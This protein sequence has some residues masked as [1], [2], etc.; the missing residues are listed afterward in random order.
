VNDFS[1]EICNS[2]SIAELA[3][4]TFMNLTG[5]L[6]ELLLQSKNEQTFSGLL[7]PQLQGMM[8]TQESRTLLELK[9]VD[10]QKLHQPTNTF[11]SS[12]N[13]HDIAIVN[14][15]GQF[16]II[17]ENKAWYHFDGAKGKLEKKVEKGVFEQI[18]SDTKKIRITLAEKTSGGRGFIL[19]NLVTPNNSAVLPRSYFNSHKS[20]IFRTSGQLG[21]Y[22]KDGVKGILSAVKSF[23]SQL[24]STSHV[25]STKV[26]GGGESAFLDV[27][28]AEV[29]INER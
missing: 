2:T 12:R 8:A 6:Q 10:Y 21:Q 18:E 11:R 29:K 4:E 3:L 9:G 25:G 1:Q 23:E 20:A 7:S 5:D 26:I 15:M 14:S 16:Q 13:F 19:L 27:I 22:R 17:I 24:L 28:C